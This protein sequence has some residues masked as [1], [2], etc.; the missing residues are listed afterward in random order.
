MIPSYPPKLSY[1]NRST[2]R[3]HMCVIVIGPFCEP[4]I[5]A[6]VP[7]H[8]REVGTAHKTTISLLR[9]LLFRQDT[10]FFFLLACDGSRISSQLAVQFLQRECIFGFR[11]PLHFTKVSLLF[12]S[13]VC[14]SLSHLIFPIRYV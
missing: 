2:Q 9:D 5:N 6:F 14:C 3:M 11:S 12:A 13:R 8:D 4:S 1:Q 7:G 10:C